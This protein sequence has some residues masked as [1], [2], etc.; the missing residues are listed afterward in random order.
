MPPLL[1]TIIEFFYKPK[2]QRDALAFEKAAKRFINYKR[3]LLPEGRIGEIESRIKD[4]KSA[5][6]NGSKR[7]SIEACNQLEF[8]CEASLPNQRKPNAFSENIEVFFVAIAIAIG[9]RGYITQPFRIPT[10]SMQPSLNGIT[11]QIINKD[12]WPPL[13][14]R[15]IEVATKGRTYFEKILTEDKELLSDKLN[16][17]II[18]EQRFNFFTYT[19]FRFKDGTSISINAPRNLLLDSEVNSGFGL[20]QKLGIEAELDSYGKKIL[21]IRN[22]VL[23]KGTVLASGYSQ[24]GDLIFVDKVSYHFRKPQRGETFVFDTRGIVGVHRQAE[25]NGEQ[26]G[27]SHYIKRLAGVPGDT[28]SIGD[29]DGKLYIDSQVATEYGFRRVME[30]KGPYA[31]NKGYELAKIG[32]LDSVMDRLTLRKDTKNPLMEE[33][34]ALGDNTDNSLD[35]RYWGTVKEYNLVGPALFSLWPFATGHWGVIE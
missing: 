15:M 10:G 16:D 30:Q 32:P 21:K 4:L 13:P 24:S 7:Q 9:I 14:I 17:S 33:Y 19:K 1:R 26:S 6:K 29:S 31:E 20:S 22:R 8:S 3:D 18:Q 2:W 5:I 34:A 12:E 23:P 35:S 11:G 25:A 27:G 28:L